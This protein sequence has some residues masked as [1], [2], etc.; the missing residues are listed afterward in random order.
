MLTKTMHLPGQA[1]DGV[2]IAADLSPY[3]NQGEAIVWSQWIY[4]CTFVDIDLEAGA[5]TK[6]LKHFDGYKVLVTLTTQR[7]VV[8]GMFDP[9]AEQ[10]RHVPFSS[11][12]T[13]KQK[14]RREQLNALGY[15][16]LTFTI[17][18]K[19]IIGAAKHRNQRAIVFLEGAQYQG[20]AM[21]YY[22]ADESWLRAISTSTQRSFHRPLEVGE[23][24]DA[25]TWYALEAS[26]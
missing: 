18:T 3:C 24:R 4:R 6:T 13:R 26:R 11:K 20:I 22:R 1:I 7:V 16:L 5:R 14:K 17:D 8:S 9:P 10:G 19:H 23:G 2:A 15:P 12:G 25:L 21:R